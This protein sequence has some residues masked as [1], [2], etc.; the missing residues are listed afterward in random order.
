[1]GRSG[2]TWVADLINFDSAYRGMFEPF[3]PD[4][5]RTA[6]PF[7]N[8]RYVHGDSQEPVLVD[9]AREILAGR[10][11]SRWVDLDGGRL[12]Y[13]R[14]LIKEVRANLM[15]RWLTGLCPT[16]SV[17]LVIRHPLAVARSWLRLDWEKVRS[18]GDFDLILAQPTLLEDY[19]LIGEAVRHIDAD[20]AFER[21][22]FTWCVSHHV[23]LTQCDTRPPTIVFYEDLLLDPEAGTQRLFEALHQPHDWER[24]APMV[25]RPSRANFLNRRFDAEQAQLLGDWQDVLSDDQIRR[26][27]QILEVFGLGGIYRGNRPSGHGWLLPHQAES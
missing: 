5:V 16:M 10:V 7:R 15:L 21:I 2:T 4:H 23:P 14:R 20:D 19:P 3:N 26:A 22:I 12:I 6:R 24:L 18:S 11:R 17:V 25:Q 9:A 8:V 1:M 13:R 27:G